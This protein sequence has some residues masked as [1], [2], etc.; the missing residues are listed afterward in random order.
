MGY[1]IQREDYD[2]NENYY[3]PNMEEPNKEQQANTEN[4]VNDSYT[5]PGQPESK[6]ADGAGKSI[7]ALVLGILSTLLGCVWFISIPV[8]VCGV[9]GIVLAIQGRKASVA[10]HGKASGIATAG[11]ITSI[12]G[13]I[14]AALGVLLFVLVVFMGVVWAFS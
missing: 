10:C 3:P 12:I 7:A 5:A 9:I 1:S 8:L 13:T 11:L 4:V 14:F 6:G 2:M